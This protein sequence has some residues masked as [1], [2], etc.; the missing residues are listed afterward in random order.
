M[1][2]RQILRPSFLLLLVCAL[3][4][5]LW[6]QDSLA[7]VEVYGG[8]SLLRPNLPAKLGGGDA[9]TEKLAEFVLGNVLGWNGGATVNLGR[10]I[11]I[12]ADL[13]G[14]YK[15]IDARVEGSDLQANARLHTFLFGPRFTRRGERV[16]PFAHALFGFGRVSGS[17]RK[18]RESES[19]SKTG[20]AAAAGGGVDFVVHKNVSI[21]A[22]QFDYFPVRNS[23]GETLTFNN[24]RWGTGV[25]INLSR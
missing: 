3:P 21:R 17:A 14:Y 1:K 7:R 24:V 15:S 20:F 23:N 6:A 11:G 10:S 9:S 19:I 5:A 12:T 8:Y 22:I 25:V 16:R 2:Y 13:S 4:A 18:D